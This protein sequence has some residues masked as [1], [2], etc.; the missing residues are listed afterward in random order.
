MSGFGNHPFQ[1]L[2]INHWIMN[3]RFSILVGD[4]G[5]QIYQSRAPK[6]LEKTRLFSFDGDLMVFPPSKIRYDG[7]L[8]IQ[9]A[10][11]NALR[12]QFGGNLY[13][14]RI[15]AVNSPLIVP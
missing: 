9:V 1:V 4:L 3:P 5:P 13:L 7:S 8:W 12:V 6:Q 2:A 15:M 10:A 14:L 11:L